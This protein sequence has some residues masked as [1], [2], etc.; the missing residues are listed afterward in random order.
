VYLRGRASARGSAPENRE[1]IIPF[2]TKPEWKNEG[3]RE[4]SQVEKA[5]GQFKTRA[6]SS[7][8]EGRRR[9]SGRNLIA[10]EGKKKRRNKS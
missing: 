10:D 3:G 5:V 2:E 7:D 9:K 4:S 6:E 1:Q 8:G